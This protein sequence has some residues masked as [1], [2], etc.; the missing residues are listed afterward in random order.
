[1]KK[2]EAGIFSLEHT[3]NC[4][5]TFGWKRIGKWF[6]DFYNNHLVLIRQDDNHLIYDSDVECKDFLLRTF[7]LDDD[8]EQI[9]QEISKDGIIKSSIKRFYGL[10]IMR[11]EHFRCLI[12]YVCSANSNIPNIKRMMNN[13]SNRYGRSIKFKG[14]SVYTFPTSRVL[15]SVSLEDLKACKLGFRAKYV[16]EISRRI[17]NGKFNLS[18][19]KNLDYIQ[20][21]KELMKLPGVGEKIA[22]CVLLF[23]FDKLESFPIDVWVRRAMIKNYFNGKK[24]SDK[25]IREFSQEY[26]GK[27]AGYAQEYLF[28]YTRTY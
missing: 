14:Y 3:L 7:R 25:K 1:M 21:K 23:S 2:I 19:L 22:D 12:S 5:Q 10:R 13:L 28:Y 8:L 16:H 24:V 4:G 18:S 20:A 15:A 26:Y 9:Y 11:Q 17:D 6:C 27:Y